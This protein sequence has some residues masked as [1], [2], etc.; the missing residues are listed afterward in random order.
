MSDCLPLPVKMMSVNTARGVN[1]PPKSTII[2]EVFC[3]LLQTR[4]FQKLIKLICYSHHHLAL[5]C[6]VL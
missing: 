1:N 5:H 2:G 3:C 6:H 4:L